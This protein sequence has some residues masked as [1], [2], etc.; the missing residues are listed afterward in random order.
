MSSG[1]ACSLH[2]NTCCIFSSWINHLLAGEVNHCRIIFLFVS[3]LLEVRKDCQENG[4]YFIFRL[5]HLFSRFNFLFNS[6]I[7]AILPSLKSILNDNVLSSLLHPSRPPMS[8]E[9]E[10]FAS[11]LFFFSLSILY[12]CIYLKFL[13]FYSF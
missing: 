3:P 2:C 8:V 7:N 9:L 11:R 1:H 5:S 6:L 4:I 12:F 13:N 10:I